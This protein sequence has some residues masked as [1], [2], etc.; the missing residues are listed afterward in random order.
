MKTR[1]LASAA[2]AACLLFSGAAAEAQLAPIVGNAA[3][4][5]V[6]VSTATTTELIPL[7]ANKST[8]ITFGHIEAA[9]TGNITFEYGT[10][11]ACATG[12]TTFGGAISLT[13]QTGFYGGSGVGP[14][15]V[16][17]AGKAFCM[18]TSAAVQISGW[19][20]YAQF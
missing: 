19:L 2:L 8:Y 3:T 1:F 11:T 17:P 9:G 6:N 12:T 14:V 15:I 4:V 20:T 16:V 5:G 7:S 13:A 18:V 10:G